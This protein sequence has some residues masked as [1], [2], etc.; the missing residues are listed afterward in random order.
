MNNSLLNKNQVLDNGTSQYVRRP[1]QRY[2]A[3]E[4][5]ERQDRF[6]EELEKTANVRRACEKAG[7]GHS[8]IYRWQ[9]HDLEFGVRFKQANAD[10]SWRLY[11][12]AWNQA[13]HGEE[14]YVV[15]AG[16][17]VY[18][19]DGN[20]LMNRKKSDKMLEMLL[21]ARLPEFRDKTLVVN[22]ILPKEYI[23]VPEDGTVL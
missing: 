16:K 11:E 19:P 2:N 10:A 9:E 17:L 4:R 14:E 13:V 12:E 15:S 20:P 7:I 8:T 5:K 18:G 21:K 22:N 1:G 6:I 3:K 23:N